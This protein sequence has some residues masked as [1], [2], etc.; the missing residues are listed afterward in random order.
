MCGAVESTAHEAPMPRLRGTLERFL[1][2]MGRVGF[3]PPTPPLTNEQMV[4][5][6]KKAKP[7]RRRFLV[8]SSIPLRPEHL[9]GPCT[10]ISA[11]RPGALFVEGVH[12]ETQAFLQTFAWRKVRM[13]ALKKYGAV[14]MCCGASPRTGAVVNVDHV[15][16]RKLFPELALVLDN[17]QVLCSD[18]NH[19]KGN[20]DQT[21]WRPEEFDAEHVSHLR[22]ISR[23]G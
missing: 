7:R 6:S 2:P 19:G 9:P 18:C 1:W 21:D 13:E 23:N 8:S 15:K 3:S 20:W 17:L 10:V 11:A 22:L 14:C 5:M 12:V 16:P 4:H